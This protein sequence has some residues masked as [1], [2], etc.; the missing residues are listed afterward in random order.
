MTKNT[1]P[2]IVIIGAGGHGKVVCDAILAQGDYHVSG[3][4]DSSVAIDTVIHYHYRVVE[5]PDKLEE[6]ANHIEYFVVA[7][8]DNQS[9][10]TLYNEALK[11]LKPATVIHPMAAVSD[12]AT[13]GH[14]SVCLAGTVVNAGVLI[15]ENTIINSGTVVDHDCSIGNHVQ[16]AV[17][18][19]VGCHTTVADHTVTEI[20]SHIK[21]FSTIG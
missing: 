8:G 17:G 6:L 1:K 2:E 13:I 4:V 16:L 19:M 5:H 10:E 3:F 20:G 14:G 18:T 12:S 11:H 15:G 7:I 9:R 21:S